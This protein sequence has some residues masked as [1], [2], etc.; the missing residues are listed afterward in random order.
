M[1][2]YNT[3]QAALGALVRDLVAGDPA[4]SPRLLP[5]E[6][7]RANGYN[8]NA[9]AAREL[10]LL[11][12]SMRAD[13]V[14]MAVVVV[15]EDDGWTI[16]D[17]FHRRVVVA[18]RLHRR[19]LPA[20]VIERPMGDRMASTVRHNRAR[21]KH[22]VELMAE[23]VRG[24]LKLGWEDDQIAKALGMSVEELLRL[25]QIAGAAKA[26]AAPTYSREWAPIQ[27]P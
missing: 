18:E 4:A 19:Y 26:L 24:M 13:G 2:I 22:S 27:E 15:A 12:E 14:T 17:G 10:S 3:T 21:G 8:P 20:S 9:V 16:V 1:A 23:L 11:E 6:K 5:V 25:R 7:V